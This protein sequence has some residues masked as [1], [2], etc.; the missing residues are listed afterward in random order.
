MTNIRGSELKEIPTNNKKNCGNC[1]NRKYATLCK[2]CFAM[3]CY[4]AV[5]KEGENIG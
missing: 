5:K 4:E 2:T 1:A 3:K